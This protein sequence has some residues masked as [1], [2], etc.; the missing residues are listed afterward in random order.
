MRNVGVLMDNIKASL[1][2]RLIQSEEIIRK[3]HCGRN[4]LK[5][6]RRLPVLHTF[7][8]SFNKLNLMT[9]MDKKEITSSSEYVRYKNW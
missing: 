7:G 1:E 3:N 6:I 4:R 9:V 2:W 8:Q 5:V